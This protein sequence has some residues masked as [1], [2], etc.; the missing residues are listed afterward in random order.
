M[1][2]LKNSPPQTLWGL[3]IFANTDPP[4]EGFIDGFCHWSINFNGLEERQLRLNSCHRRSAHKDGLLQ[5]S[6]GPHQRPGPC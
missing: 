4:L 6:Q 2:S 1:P 3:T 5:A